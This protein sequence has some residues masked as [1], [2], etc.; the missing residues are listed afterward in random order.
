MGSGDWIMASAQVRALNEKTKEKVLVVDRKGRPQWNEI[1]YHNP[2]IIRVPSDAPYV[3]L[4]NGPGLRPYIAEKTATRF[5]WQRWP[6]EPGEIYFDR[7][8]LDYASPYGSMV[9]VEP[10]TKLLNGNKS[11]EWSRWQTVVDS[12]VAD[13]IQVGSHKSRWL[14]NV[15]RVETPTMRHA[16]AIQ[17]LSRAFIGCEGGLHHAAA[18]LGIPAV[19]LFA[20]YVGPDI[21][22]Y[23]AHRNLRHAGAACG[24]ILP[25]E[26]CK[27]SMAAITVDEVITNLKEIL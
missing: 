22:G 11:W 27:A 17:S 21:T 26:G 6:I 2:R 14:K 12:G 23:P 24:S 16:M 25:C 7:S 18:A 4:I 20:E 19:V 5:V 10:N 13:F 8:E 9:M 1:F 15:R 3:R